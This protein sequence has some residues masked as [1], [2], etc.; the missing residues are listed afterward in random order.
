M[1][2]NLSLIIVFIENP[3]VEDKISTTVTWCKLTGYEYDDFLGHHDGF[4]ILRS[5]LKNLSGNC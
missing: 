1:W 4:R 2:V 5:Y 3:T